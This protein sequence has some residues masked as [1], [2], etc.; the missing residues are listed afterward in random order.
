MQASGT[1]HGK[2]N[3]PAMP[4]APTANRTLVS[5]GENIDIAKRRKVDGKHDKE[6]LRSARRTRGDAADDTD[7]PL[8]ELRCEDGLVLSY[9]KR[10]RH[11]RAR[12]AAAGA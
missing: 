2:K 6:F 7:G 1:H 3:A 10:T 4:T 8:T 9:R 5:D 12:I 11:L